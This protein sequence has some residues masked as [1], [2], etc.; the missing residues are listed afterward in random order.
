MKRIIITIAACLSAVTCN[1]Q[2]ETTLVDALRGAAQNNPDFMAKAAS[3]NAQRDIISERNAALKPQLSVLA[4]SAWDKRKLL[5]SNI[6]S[7][8]QQ[9][10]VAIIPRWCH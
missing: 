4:V 5:E 7:G 6:E 9:I 1:L 8:L 3:L 2:A 10:G